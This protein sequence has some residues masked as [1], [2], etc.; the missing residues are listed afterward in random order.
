MWR[1]W[2]LSPALRGR[3]EREEKNKNKKTYMEYP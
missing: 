3:K 2:V 1:S